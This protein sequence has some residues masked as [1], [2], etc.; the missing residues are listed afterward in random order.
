MF[1]IPKFHRAKKNNSGSRSPRSSRR[2]ARG[3]ERLEARLALSG[4]SVLP[5]PGTPPKAMFNVVPS[6]GDGNPYGVSIVPA[7]F[8]SGGVLHSGEA[9]VVNFNSAASGQGFGTTI[10]LINPANSATTPATFFTSTRQGVTTPPVILKSGFVVVGNV[11]AGPG[12]TIAQ[13]AI[14]V[15]DKN[16]HLVTTLTNSHF[17][18]DPW[19]VTA[20]DLGSFVQLFVSNVSATAGNLGTVTRIDMTIVNGKPRVL[21]MVRIASGYPSRPDQSAFVVGPS[22]LA[23]NLF[24]DT[25]YVASEDQT[26]RGVES[27]AVF[28]ISNAAITFADHGEGTLIYA[29]PAHLHGPVGLVLAPDGNLVAANADSVNGDPNQPSEL[30]EF[31]VHGKFVRQFSVDPSPGGA[32]ALTFGTI[33]GHFSLAAVDDNTNTLD[34]WT[35]PAPI[36][37]LAAA[38]ALAANQ[39]TAAIE[40]ALAGLLHAHE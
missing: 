14:Q 31:S 2:A 30:V 7:G 4:L 18:P 34:I 10:S 16:G 1:T 9:L 27:G 39:T 28:A 23:F 20:N 21:D 3:V 40:A 12:G 38:N 25:L 11:P 6:N 24:T 32:F 26:I 19:Y 36:P 29:D 17:L 37:A 35:E 5:A 15:I 13:G 22:G 33:A 8:P